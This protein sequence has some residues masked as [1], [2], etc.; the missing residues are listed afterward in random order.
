VDCSGA[1]ARALGLQAATALAARNSGKMTSAACLM[2]TLQAH[3][4]IHEAAWRTLSA[5]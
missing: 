3:G 5:R 2:L 1:G 4:S